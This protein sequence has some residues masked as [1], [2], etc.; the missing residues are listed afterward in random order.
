MAASAIA[1]FC[2]ELWPRRHH[3]WTFL[4]VQGVEPTNNT[5]ERTLRP[6]AIYRKLSFGTQSPSRSR[7][8]ER[9]LTVSETCRLQ[10]RN[11]F[12]YLV[13]AMEAKFTEYRASSLLPAAP[14]AEQAA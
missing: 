14:A 10:D 11:A 13:A 5:A 7:H 12:E 1:G 3:L 9:L 2:D 6:M 4:R 8:L